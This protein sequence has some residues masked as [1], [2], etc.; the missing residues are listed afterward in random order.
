MCARF[1]SPRNAN[2][3]LE[4]FASSPAFNFEYDPNL[5]P[6]GIT[7]ILCNDENGAH[8]H[9][10]RFGL[11]PSWVRNLEK[12]PTL[13]NARAETITEKSSFKTPYAKRRC[14]IPCEAF[15]E[16]RE[17]GERKRKMPY[18]FS[19]KDGSLINLAGIYNHTQIENEWLVSFSIVTTE[20]EG[21]VRQYH[22]RVPIITD[23]VD[24]WL[25]PGRS[26]VET[27][28]T[29]PA[30]MFEIT[31]MNPSMNSTGVKDVE[32]LRDSY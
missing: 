19:R 30:S 15:Y 3:L 5:P 24:D 21:V 8:W 25:D 27:I 14:I 29:L 20:S 2:R 31:A 28:P 16:W 9:L 11:V 23:Y 12:L 22:H 7:P 18:K 10:A 32:P 13:H 17:E 1:Q 26:T 6:T 4:C